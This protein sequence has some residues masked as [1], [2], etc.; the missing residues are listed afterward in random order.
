MFENVLGQPAADQLALDISGRRLAPAMLFA[1]PPA[2]GKGTAALELGRILSCENHGAPWNC[3]CPSC[4]R[5]RLLLHPDL[6]CLGPRPFS[7]EIAASSA[8]FLGEPSAPAARTLFIRSVR[9]LLLRFNPA[10]WEDDPKISKFGSLATDLEEGLDELDAGISSDAEALKK[11]VASIQN[12]AFK[13]ESAGISESIPIA[14]IRRAAWWCR[15]APAGKGK[16]FLIENADCMQEGARNSLLKLLEEPPGPV[17][18]ILTTSR[19]GALIQTIRSRLRPYRFAARGASA[20][21]EVI[22]RVFRVEENGAGSHSAGDLISAYLDS[23]LPVS[24]GTLDALAAFF[25]ASAAYKAALL[26]KKKS[27]H[28]Q[29][30]AVVLLG[31]YAAPLAEKAGLGRP[32]SGCGEAA[33][34][35]LK[36]AADF[37]IRSMFS[38]FLRFLLAH[39]SRGVRQMA[40]PGLI[41][42]N[43]IWKECAASCDSAVTVYN[44]SPALALERLF[45]DTS[46]GMA[47]L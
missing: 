38:R 8:A 4:A 44:Q 18:L 24:G 34:T 6:L 27:P 40:S 19:P 41:A 7:A 1:G 23:F 3:G 13:L 2:S 10:L 14:Q 47:E 35:V 33:S 39:V 45:T 11:S 22:R 32:V 36:G 43:K 16:L 12:D 31:K 17:T 21:R 29:S 9:K 42:Y 5:H 25:A 37:E 28:A 15:L 26:G 30:E 46:R 20:E